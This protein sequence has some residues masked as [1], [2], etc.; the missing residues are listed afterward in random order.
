[1]TTKAPP[2]GAASHVL[3]RRRWMAR[4][5]AR[6]P[7]GAILL[8]LGPI[9]LYY[10]IFILYPL[11]ATV[12]YSFHRIEPLPGRQGL[13]TT[14]VEFENFDDLDD[15][16]R[17]ERAVKNTLKWGI[18]GPAIEMLTAL[19]LALV[20][21]FKVPFW[22]FY[23]IAWFTPML[24]SGVI[25]GLVWRWI[26]NNDWGLLNT[27]LREVGLDAWAIDWLGARDNRNSPLAVVIFVH[28]WATFGYSFVL[29]LAGLTAIDEEVL[30][31]A[32]VDGANTLQVVLRV[33]LPLL[34]PTFITVLIL[35][36]MGKM[37]AFNVVW[38]LTGGGPLHLSETVATYV[39]KRAFGWRTLDL[40][41][42]S[43]IAVAWFGVVLVGVILI[44]T[45]SNR[46]ARY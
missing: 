1:M 34:R 15:D 10:I 27:A 13:T 42:P 9:M 35:S 33:M 23:R 39:Q 32:R 26:F 46:M 40:G 11:G 17:F 24:V 38:V 20:V 19:T 5:R 16:W 30:E 8:F 36:F 2:H 44:R 25:V 41:Y 7:W 28:Y 14:Y 18:I 37:R 43:A 29:L 6:K 45:L 4:G 21:Y 22:R 3:A 12:Y 31:A